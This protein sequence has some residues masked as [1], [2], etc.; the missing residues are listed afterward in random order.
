MNE[1]YEPT[2]YIEWWTL[3]QCIEY[4]KKLNAEHE[5]NMQQL[6]KIFGENVQ[7]MD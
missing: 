1:I 6:K 7:I 4:E 2:R 3:E 5:A